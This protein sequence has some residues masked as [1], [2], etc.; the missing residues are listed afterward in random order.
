MKKTLLSVIA[1][2]AVINV[3]SAVPSPADRKALC[4]K[5]PEKYVWVE[6]D[7]FCA[8]INPCKSDNQSVQ[9]AYCRDVEF[10]FDTSKRDLVVNRLV[11]KWGMGAV[12]SIKDFDVEW[13]GVVT[14]DGHYFA[15]GRSNRK[16]MT[17]DDAVD[18]AFYA[19]NY[20]S[21]LD[22]NGEKHYRVGYGMSIEEC[23]DIQDFASLLF[24]KLVEGHYEGE[25]LSCWIE[26]D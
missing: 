26:V 16:Y 24:E 19:Y 20:N 5:H 4:E 13:F 14:S 10:P 11:E 15:A 17:L 3:A 18:N 23:G 21:R 25:G 6:R 1:G 22:E 2:L 7:Q 9:L 12:V 8:P